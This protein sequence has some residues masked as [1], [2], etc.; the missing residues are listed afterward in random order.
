MIILFQTDH[1]Y[2]FFSYITLVFYN[3]QRVLYRID[4]MTSV[5]T[6]LQ[7]L[8]YWMI[9]DDSACLLWHIIF[10]GYYYFPDICAYLILAVMDKFVLTS[11]LPISD[12]L[13]T[14][15]FSPMTISAYEFFPI[16]FILPLCWT[17]PSPN[18]QHTTWL[19]DFP[20]VTYTCASTPWLRHGTSLIYILTSF[21][22]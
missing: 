6:S 13:I 2:F 1:S 16:F 15:F 9:Y 22:E 18:Y 4:M 17:Q 5:L 12:I 19:R 21:R 20:S 11:Y 14:R 10:D 3:I 8:T 7:N